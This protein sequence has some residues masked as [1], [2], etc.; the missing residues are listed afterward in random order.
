MR[1]K[2]LVFRELYLGRKSYL[3]LSAIWLFMIVIGIM[4]Q[5][6]ILYG[7]LSKQL[8]E[9][10][11]ETVPIMLAIFTYIPAALIMF[12]ASLNLEV[13]F[14]DYFVKWNVFSVTTPVGERKYVG[15]KYLIKISMLIVAFGLSVLNA[16][17]LSSLAGKTLDGRTVTIMLWMML[18]IS[19]VG[20]VQGQLAYKYR[21]KSK[22]EKMTILYFIILYA[23]FMSIFLISFFAFKNANPGIDGD[24]YL[25]AFAG[26]LE[27]DFRCL[28][29]GFFAAAPFLPIAVITVLAIG[30]CL[31]VK[32]MKRRD[33]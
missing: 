30:Y 4:I 5:L 29:G 32:A 17:V 27:A 6:S 14:S 28:I 31:D 22:T 8:A 26:Q 23:F 9:E 21:D 12:A 7:N 16:A 24:M 1:L 13:I 2:G 20:V 15:V 25:D 11:A 33:K 19:I 10:L 18:V 3:L